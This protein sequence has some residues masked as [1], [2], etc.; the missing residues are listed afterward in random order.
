M[1]QTKQTSDNLAKHEEQDMRASGY[2]D[3][4]K[5]ELWLPSCVHGSPRHMTALAK[6]ALFWFLNF[7]VYIYSLH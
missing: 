1:G 5:N 2:I 7:V 6:N 3:E 4:P